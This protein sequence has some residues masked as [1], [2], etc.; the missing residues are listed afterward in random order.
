MVRATFG[1]N[2]VD[3]RRYFLYVIYQTLGFKEETEKLQP[4]F[5]TWFKSASAQRKEYPPAGPI[6]LFIKNKG[7]LIEQLDEAGIV[8]TKR[9]EIFLTDFGRRILGAFKVEM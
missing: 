6:S 8:V 3:M 4:D 5:V 2:P 7:M 9:R 1:R